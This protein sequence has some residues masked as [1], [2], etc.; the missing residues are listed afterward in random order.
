LCVADG[1]FFE[2]F[3]AR[4]QLPWTVFNR[5]LGH[6]AV[7]AAVLDQGCLTDLDLAVR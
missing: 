1:V 5:L 7:I 3:D 6:A 2:D 4:V